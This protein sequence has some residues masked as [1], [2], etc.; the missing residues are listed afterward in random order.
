MASI[1]EYPPGAPCWM[2]LSTTDLEG[3]RKFYSEVLGWKDYEIA[4][5]EMGFYSIP[6]LDDRFVVG[7]ATQQD[8]EKSM[9]V[10]PH[11]NTYISV[12][13][14]DDA[15][16]KAKGLGATVVVEPFDVMDLGR[17]A[18]VIDPVGA[19]ISVWEPKGNPGAG[20]MQEPG[21]V[22]WIE[23]D[24]KDAQTAKEFYT[25]LFGW[26]ANEHKEPVPYTEWQLNGASVG[27]ML[28]VTPDMGEIPP[29]WQ[30]FFEVPDTD[31][32]VAKAKKAG[33]Q[34]FVEPMDVPAGRFAVL[35][36]SQGAVFSVIKSTER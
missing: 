23:L 13:S 19:A 29:N 32:A 34:V 30:V 12:E 9:G 11:W 25:A 1:T 17:M 26:K 28:T 7:M 16:T 20:V 36:D 35:A 21:A 6:K 18:V 15:A 10:P 22:A 24:V 2:E 5:E 3:A 14:A 27:G 31:D 4:G 8:A 33:G